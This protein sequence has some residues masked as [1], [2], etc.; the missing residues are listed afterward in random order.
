MPE[1]TIVNY[2]GG[3]PLRCTMRQIGTVAPHTHGEMELDLVLTGQCQVTMGETR[4]TAGEEAVFSIPPH[5]PHSL[6]GNDCCII[7]IQF[8]QTF[9]E[10]TLPNPKHPDFVCNSAVYGDNPSFQ[11]LRRLI[12]RLVKN[13]AEQQLGYELRNWSIIYAIM[14]VMY[15]EFRVDES[16]AKNQRAHRYTARMEQLSQ[17]LN[18]HYQENLT[19]RSLADQ[20]HLSVPYLSK[21]FEKQ[22]GVSFLNY[23]TRIRLNHAL[24]A[25]LHTDATIEAISADSGFPNSH[26]FVQAF[27]KEFGALPS[28]YR[29]QQMQKPPE[30]PHILEPQQHDYM[31]GLKKYLQEP[32]QTLQPQAISSRGTIHCE[33]VQGKL[34]HKWKT[35]LAVT[36]AHALLLSDVQQMLSRI[37]REIGFAYVKFN[38]I[39]SDEMHL[40]NETA[41]GKVQLS[42]AYVDKAL[43]FLRSIGLKPFIQLGFMPAAL[44]CENVHRFQ[45]S[46]SAPSSYP[47]WCSMVDQLIAH[48]LQRYGQSEIHSWLFCLWDQPDLAQEGSIFA[49]PA[50]FYGFYRQTRDIVKARDPKISFGAPATFYLPQED[51]WYLCFLRWCEAHDCLPDFLN[52]HY[53]DLV[54]N[55]VDTA[56]QTFG[57]WES[58]TLRDTPD[59]FSKFAAQVLGDR[60]KLH[61]ENLPIY[62]TEWNNTPSQQDLLN[63]TCFKSCYIVKCILESY[64]KLD[65]F[66]YWSLTD[67]MGEGPQPEQQFFGGLGLFTADSIPKAGYYAFTLLRQL[68]DSFLGKGEGWFATRQGDSYRIILYNYRHFAHLY[69]LGERFDMTFTDRYT[70]F[71]PEQMLDV[72][73][74]LDGIPNGAYLVTEKIIN[75]RSGS[76]FDQWVSMGALELSTQ[77]EKETLA[78]RTVPAINRYRASVSDNTLP[79]EAL[80]DMLEVRLVTV[81]PIGSAHTEPPMF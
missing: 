79:V 21:F 57:F 80:L 37:Q 70:P 8:E 19:L 23:L 35:M 39:L 25:L 58:M 64:D 18:D 55:S 38:G 11:Q 50:A 4:F 48:L 1:Y 47:K 49:D 34:R 72:S 66:A 15:Q 13:N 29:R 51:S 74:N 7:T 5:V 33:A 20:V 27:R 10:R 75:R 40:Y 12:A 31:A 60:R 41:A 6:Y 2:G 67:W 36:S 17:I 54:S 59:G 43:D 16:E 62:L 56:Q 69:A 53:Y 30:K 76:A 24:E 52:F 46:L 14:D 22:F 71:S 65:S 44:S 32:T 81:E 42:F 63:D 68:G 28:I 73:L 9:F 45:Y 61:L 77:E 78:C 3:N 26:A